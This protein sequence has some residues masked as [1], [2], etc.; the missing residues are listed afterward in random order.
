MAVIENHP[1]K[2]TVNLALDY[3]K[4]DK[5]AERKDEETMSQIFYEEIPD[6]NLVVYKTQT[7]ILNANETGDAY[8]SFK[9]NMKLYGEKEI[10]E[11]N[12]KTKDGKAILAWHYIQSFEGRI[13]PVTAHE[14]GVKLAQKMFHGFPVQVSTHTDKD[15]THNHI[16]VCAWANDGHK[17]NQD[18][19]TYQ[20]IREE[21]DRLCD[22]YGLSVIEHTRH[23]KLVEWTDSEGEKHYYEPTD[24]KNKMLEERERGEITTDSVGSYRNTDA[25]KEKKQKED[26]LTTQIKKDIDRFLPYAMDYEHLLRMLRESGYKIRDKKKSGEWLSHVTFTP[27]GADPN[28]RGKRDYM[29][30]KEDGYYTRE[31]LTRVIA[32][33]VK[34]RGFTH[35]EDAPVPMRDPVIMG[36]Y[37]YVETDVSRIDENYRTEPQ[38]D[39]GFII[40]RRGE[41]ERDLIQN[42]R[43]KDLE[44]QVDLIDMSDLDRAIREARKRSPE[45]K[46][47][48]GETKRERLVREIQENL[49]S[50]SF[51]EERKVYTYQQANTVISGLYERHKSCVLALDEA[52]KKLGGYDVVLSLPAR[53]ENVKRNMTLNAG[54]PEYMSGAGFKNDTQAMRTLEAAIK[55]A[56][57]DT[58]EGM[59]NL[60]KQ[61]DQRAQAIHA[62][63]GQVDQILETVKEYQKCMEV[64]R[65]IDRENGGKRAGHFREYDFIFNSQEAAE[66]REKQEAR[67]EQRQEPKKQRRGQDRE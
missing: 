34:S 44:I 24:R 26:S 65:R 21:S 9:R 56:G 57:I 47:K 39:G 45:E 58:P 66:R 48:T 33:N 55:K 38:K 31:N 17:W 13:D 30:S 18:N 7:S 36:R 40:F 23:Q 12:K 1:I 29:L 14:I 10:K 5:V 63:S 59:E 35:G 62:L 8:Q 64:L 41:M 4:S 32:E 46:R 53:L 61:K 2:S 11:G 3:G 27:P 51:I 43:Q 52:K 22:E 49:D 20:A 19:K 42:T 54:I 37:E 67:Q 28:S 15:N 50:L 6:S 16:I 25:Y 60:K